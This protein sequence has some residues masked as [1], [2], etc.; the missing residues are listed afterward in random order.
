[1]CE[2]LAMSANVPVDAC[3]HL[4]GLFKRGGTTGPHKD[5]WGIS[6]YEGRACHVFKDTLPSVSSAMA[7]F[8]E[9][10][11]IH[12]ETILAHIRL[13]N[14]GRVH[15]ENTHPFVRELWGRHWTFMHN[16]QLKGERQLALNGPF[17][18]VGN[19]DSEYAFCWLMEQIAAR[20]PKP[21]RQSK[22]LWRFIS[23]QLHILSSFGVFNAILCDS[24]YLYVNCSTKLSYCVRQS[25]FEEI[26]LVDSDLSLDL[27]T[28]LTAD[29]KA[30]ILATVPLTRNECWTALKKGEQLVMEKGEIVARFE[31]E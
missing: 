7:R 11:P 21:P 29:A 20:F 31:A 3:F 8:V 2:L 27:S 19:T 13:A 4:T 10:H 17:L 12:S 15:L 22:T 26:H 14:R 24:T 23:E 25:P 30:V 6:F 16:G 18:P 9:T 5:G 1:M 28:H